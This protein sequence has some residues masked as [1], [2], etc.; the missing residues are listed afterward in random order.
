M[1]LIIGLIFPDCDLL[2]ITTGIL[3]EM[4]EVGMSYINKRDF[5]QPVHN[6]NGTFEYSDNWWAGSFKDIVFNIAGF[7]TGKMIHKFLFVKD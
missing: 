4:I 6:L 1:F 3:W 2:A 7:Y 5:S